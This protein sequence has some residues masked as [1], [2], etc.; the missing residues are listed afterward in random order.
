VYPHSSTTLADSL[1][2][3]S[4]S[5]VH[6]EMEVRVQLALAELEQ[7]PQ[8]VQLAICT[9]LLNGLVSKLTAS[10]VSKGI[11][12]ARTEG[13]P[14]KPKASTT[15][16][17]SSS[18]TSA[19]DNVPRADSLLRR[20][21]DPTDPIEAWQRYGGS[22]AQL[23]DVLREEPTGVLDNMLTHRNMPGGP[24]VRVKS[25]DKLAETIAVRLEQHFGRQSPL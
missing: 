16:G 24:K 17:R 23:F 12:A 25:R 11:T 2:S 4:D 10:V 6:D 1:A 7:L 9:R 5:P 8:D 14:A 19:N 20:L 13:Q 3:T 18:R 21:N 15:K 22:A